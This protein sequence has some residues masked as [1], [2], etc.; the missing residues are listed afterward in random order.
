MSANNGLNATVLFS[1]GLSKNDPGEDHKGL[2][3]PLGPK[4]WHELWK[5]SFV[6]GV[7][8]GSLTLDC[9]GVHKGTEI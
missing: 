7:I 4:C 3:T 6:F 1:C 2:W 8:Q 9:F 5:K